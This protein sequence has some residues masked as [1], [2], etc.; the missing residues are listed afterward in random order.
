[1][2]VR[3]FP[4]RVPDPEPDEDSVGVGKREWWHGW[5]DPAAAALSP[6]GH[7]ARVLVALALLVAP[8]LPDAILIKSTLDLVLR[9]ASYLSWIVAVGLSTL[10]LGLAF[11]SGKASRRAQAGAGAPERHSSRMLG[12]AWLG[13]GAGLFALRLVAGLTHSV[14]AAFQGAVP[15]AAGFPWAAVGFAGLMLVVY[16]GTGALAWWDGRELTNPA[17]TL[18]RRARRARA[19]LEAGLGEGRGRVARLIELREVH[20]HELATIDDGLAN[21]RASRRALAGVLKEHARV[22]IALALGDAR[23]TGGVHEPPRSRHDPENGPTGPTEPG[24]N[25]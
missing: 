19:R 22:Q 4:S 21:A 8:A 18:L 5:A 15:T 3:P 14:T 16:A 11:Q 12:W 2:S 25:Q 10:A 20:L 1:M 7:R 13:I 17:E 9:E 24:G 6:G 23:A